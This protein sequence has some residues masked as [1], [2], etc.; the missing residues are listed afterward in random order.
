MRKLESHSTP[1]IV[2]HWATFVAVAVA[3]GLAFAREFVESSVERAALMDLHRSVGVTVLAL[4]L[5]RAL[6]RLVGPKAP[7]GADLPRPMRVAA[8]V[9][10]VLLYALLIVTPLL[11]WALTSAANRVVRP[12]GLFDLPALVARNRELADALAEWHES[13]AFTLL[14]IIGVH[15]AAALY[16]HFARRD[17]VLVSMLPMLRRRG[18]K[19]FDAGGGGRAAT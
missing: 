6:A 1:L 4:T 19:G 5:V 8:R 14:A 9:A 7:S 17:Q 13:C 15:A 3:F 16:H 18:D 2:L 11:G 12:F 10:H